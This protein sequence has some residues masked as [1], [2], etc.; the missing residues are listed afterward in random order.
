MANEVIDWVKQPMNDGT[1]YE[2]NSQTFGPFVIE[3]KDTRSYSIWWGGADIGEANSVA[4]AKR[5][6][7]DHANSL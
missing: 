7:T 5:I 2:G 1:R 3:K 4:A 6:A